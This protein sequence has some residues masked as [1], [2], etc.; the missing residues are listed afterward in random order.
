MYTFIIHQH[1]DFT[2]EVRQTFVKLH[3]TG[4]GSKKKIQ[5][6]HA[7]KTARIR[8]WAVIKKFKTT[9]AVMNLPGKGCESIFP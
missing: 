2:N 8:C 6:L 5:K 1:G 7:L 9:G 3:K 4:N